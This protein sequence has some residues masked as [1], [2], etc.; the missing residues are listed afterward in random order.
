MRPK[1][2]LSPSRWSSA[3]STVSEP[4]IAASTTIIVPRPIVVNSELPDTNI[5]AIAISTVAPEIEHRLAR[6][7]RGAQ[8][9]L[10]RRVA[11]LPLL[12]L[13]AQVEERVVDPDG[14]AD[15]EDD[16]AER[17]LVR[18]HD[19]A[20][21]LVEPGRREHGRERE[22]HRQAGGDERAERDDEDR[23]RQRQRGQLGAAHVA[24][25]ALV[26]LVVRRGL[27]ELLDDQAGLPACT[28]SIALRIGAILS[29][30]SSALPLTSNWTSAECR[31]R[32]IEP[33]VALL[34]RRDDRS[35]RPTARQASARRAAT[36]AANAGSS[37]VAR[38]RLDEHA[39][40]RRDVEVARGR[41]SARRAATR[42]S[43]SPTA[44]SAS[45]RRRRRRR[46]RGRRR[47]SSRTR[48][49]SSARRSSAPRGRRGWDRWTP[50]RTP[51]LETLRQ[52]SRTARRS[53]RG[54]YGIAVGET[55][56]P[57]GR[58]GRDLQK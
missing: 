7:P 53:H 37:T 11:A 3:G 24:L 42:R 5:P 25:E 6:R 43:R 56:D 23:D 31:S 10:V 49:S 45:R 39:L 38:R 29:F 22:Q 57:A 40:A 16:R 1:S 58:G 19:V 41:G 36:A 30:A 20:G 4:I 21:E 9:R 51:W 33:G 44:S 14:H 34:D 47:R 27:A 32:E 28:S 26:D 46:P 48:P 13:A 54:N 52:A 2:T 55:T 17:L 18:R 15:H 12:S 35:R 50:W 8:Q